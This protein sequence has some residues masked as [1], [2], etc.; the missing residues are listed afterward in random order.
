M[1]RLG[2]SRRGKRSWFLLTTALTIAGALGLFLTGV[3]A[4]DVNA[5]ETGE[6]TPPDPLS[7]KTLTEICDSYSLVLIR[8]DFEILHNGFA[9][10][11]CGDGRLEDDMRCELDWPFND[12]PPCTAYDELRN[13]IYMHYGYPFTTA[14][15]QDRAQKMPGYER[16]EDFSPSWLSEVA[17]KNVETLK[18]LK[19]DRVACQ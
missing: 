7:G 4:S 13:A 11:C 12:V 3:I 17:K 19:Q 6:R 5:A 16:R 1:L 10:I 18:R 2:R 14:K 15:W 9:D 8:F